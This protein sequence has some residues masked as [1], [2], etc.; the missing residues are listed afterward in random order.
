LVL[1]DLMMPDVD[2]FAVLNYMRGREHLRLVPVIILSGRTLSYE[3][4]KRIDHPFVTFQSKDILSWDE[5]ATALRAAVAGGDQLAQPTS[6][7]VK[8]AIA[9]IQQHHMRDLSRQEIAEAI[10]VSKNYITQI[11]HQELG[12]SLWDYLTRYRIK[13]AKELLRGTDESIATIAEQVGFD[14]ASYFGRVFRKQ[15]GCSPQAYREHQTP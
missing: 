3:D 13:R 8:R 6:L 2:G 10:G 12:I 1:L 14:D 15:A 4:I 11:F 5:I 9:Y 7:L